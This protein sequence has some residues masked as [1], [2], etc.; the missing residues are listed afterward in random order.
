MPRAAPVTTTTRSSKRPMCF[1]SESVVW[2]AEEAPG[3]RL[4]TTSP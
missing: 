2:L 4:E 3:A 1:S